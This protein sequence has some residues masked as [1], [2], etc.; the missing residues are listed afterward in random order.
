MKRYRTLSQSPIAPAAGQ[1][2]VVKPSP[3]QRVKVSSLIATFT[4]SATAANR[5]VY[6]QILD[7]NAVPVF[8]TG[9]PTA[10]TASGVSDF[11]LST[12]FGQPNA[13]QGPVNAAVGLGIPAMW[14]PPSWSI[15]LSAISLQA[16]DQFSAIS[17]VGEFAEDIWDQE[18]DQALAL[19]F[20]STFA[21]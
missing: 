10:I 9:S 6:A 7:P 19:Q 3:N 13:L 16:G 20:L 4:A 11:V 12:A 14:L 2:A 18:E 5:F 1:G 17:Y 15:K 21:A 8:E